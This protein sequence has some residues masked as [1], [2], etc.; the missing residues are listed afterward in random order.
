MDARETASTGAGFRDDASA[1]IRRVRDSLTQVVSTIPGFTYRRPND[2]AAELGLDPKLA[3]KIGRC[4]EAPDPFVAAQLIPGPA[5]IKTFLRA[6]ARRRVP[7]EQVEELRESVDRF[8]ELVRTHAG[9]RKNFNMLATGIADTKLASADAEHRRKAYEGNSFIWGVHARTIFRTNLLRPCRDSDRWDLL[10]I[11]GFIDF[12]RLR[13]NVAWRLSRPSS[14]DDTHARHTEVP[15]EAIDPGPAAEGIDVPLLADFCTRPLPQFR[16]VVGPLGHQEYEFVAA[17]VGNT[18][19]MSC[20]TGEVLR[21]VE[22]RYR[23][24]R[25]ETLALMFPV[26][27][28]AEVLVFDALVH[29]DLFA[30]RGAFKGGLFGDL[31]GGGPTLRYEDADRLPLH[32]PLQDLGAGLDAARTPDIPRYLDMLRYSLA[33]VGWD[34]DEFEVYRLRMQYPPI[35]ATVEIKRPLPPPPAR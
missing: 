25:Y 1:T 8:C 19:R 16:A 23:S 10:T 15:S 35:P 18:A 28:P 22:P 34:G 26:R 12:C 17:S 33:R 29:R 24:D 30:D 21:R 20:V 11:R 9:S 14:V 3:W 27:L 2:L 4:I 32:D 13:P 31:F 6:A 7:A 5:G